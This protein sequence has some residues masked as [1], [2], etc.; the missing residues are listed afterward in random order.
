MG[1]AMTPKKTRELAEGDIVRWVKGRKADRQHTFTV[2]WV[3]ADAV[4]IDNGAPG[5]PDF[6]DSGAT[7]TAR[8]KHGEVEPWGDDPPRFTVA[9]KV[10]ARLAAVEAERDEAR[11][12][13]GECYVLSGADTD[14]NEPGSGHLWPTAVDAVRELRKDYDEACDAEYE[15]V[16][17][18]N[19]YEARAAESAGGL[20]AAIDERDR[21]VRI[22]AEVVRTLAEI[23]SITA[24]VPENPSPAVSEY[25]LYQ[26]AARCQKAMEAADAARGGA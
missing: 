10:A 19:M 1:E 17:E 24:R 23:A 6:S 25:A 15:A 9:A 21:L 12:M 13:L 3:G 26:I 20:A 18:R 16:R 14:G 11:R 5:V 4:M 7:V 8:V 2:L 22:L